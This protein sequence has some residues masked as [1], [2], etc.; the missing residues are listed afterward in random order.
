MYRI[1]NWE[2]LFET[3]ESRKL[4]NLYWVPVP[5]KHDGLHF[6]ALIEGPNALESYAVWL[7]LVQVASKCPK[8][9]LLADGSGRGLTPKDIAR[10]TGAPL[11]GLER[12]IKAV[13]EQTDWL[14]VVAEKSA[15]NP[16]KSAGNP[17]APADEP[18]HMEYR[19]TGKTGR[20]DPEG[21]IPSEVLGEDP[22]PGARH[23]GRVQAKENPAARK[24]REEAEARRLKD[25]Q[26]KLSTLRQTLDRFARDGMKPVEDLERMKGIAK[27]IRQNGGALPGGLPSDFG[28]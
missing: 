13:L 12:G 9:G 18:R 24:L 26:N 21:S 2:E 6:R 4:K 3:H 27:Y 14:E 1:R 16:E 5:N 17:A 11:S 15:E 22:P 23:T 19:N 8:R 28:K 10:K 20:D 25:M 7:L